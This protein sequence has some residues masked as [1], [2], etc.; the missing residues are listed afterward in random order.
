M[1]NAVQISIFLDRVGE[2]RNMLKI[3]ETEKNEAEKTLKLLREKKDLWS[4]LKRPF[5]LSGW[6]VLCETANNRFSSLE[7]MSSM[8]QDVEEAIESE[9]W[10]LAFEKAQVA[11]T[12]LENR[13]S[14]FWGHSVHAPYMIFTDKVKDLCDF[15]K[16]VSI[17]MSM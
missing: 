3:L 2:Y 9:E 8:I 17:A 4:I 5:L 14:I 6:V 10:R 16:N 7:E 15:L 13:E 12:C 1:K 11:Y